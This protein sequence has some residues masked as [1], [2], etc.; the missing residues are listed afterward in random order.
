[1][2]A[3]MEQCTELDMDYDE[4]DKDPSEQKRA[5]AEELAKV[6]EAAME[7]RTYR[8]DEDQGAKLKALKYTDQLAAASMSC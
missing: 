6:F 4:F 2:V 3:T 7:C 1:M 8:G 5:K